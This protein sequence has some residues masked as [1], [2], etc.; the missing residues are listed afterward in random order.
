MDSRELAAAIA[1]TASI[2]AV[3]FLG[4]LPVEMGNQSF[5]LPEREVV[6]SV[7]A[8]TTLDCRDDFTI[9]DSARLANEIDIP[10]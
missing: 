5:E 2:A 10:A 1:A 9:L 4:Q 7:T 3:K 8:E 6:I